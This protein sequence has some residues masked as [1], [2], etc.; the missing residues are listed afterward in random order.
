MS[1]WKNAESAPKD[2]TWVLLRGRNSAGQ[3]MVPIV[4]AFN[5]PGSV[6]HFGWVDVGSFKPVDEAAVEWTDL[7][8][9]G[10]PK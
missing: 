3:P 2:G 7:P 4:A 1:E 6:K 10:D 9:W 8:D 5:P